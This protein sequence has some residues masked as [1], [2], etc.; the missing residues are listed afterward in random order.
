VQGASYPQQVPEERR[1]A[2]FFDLDKTIIAKSS[3]LAFGKPFFQGG[4]LN[5]RAVLRSAYAQFVFAL[6]GA[7][8]DQMDRMRSYLASMCA[9]WDVQ[10][11]RDIV[12]ETLHKV[13]DPLVHTEAVE[14]IA[15]HHETGRAVYVVSASG[16]EVVEPIAKMLGADA[17]IA[18]TMVVRDGRYTGEIEFYAYGPAKAEAIVRVADENGYDLADCYAY[19]DSVTDLPMLE[20]VGHPAAVNP[21]RALRKE[22]IQRGW[23]V[24][25]FSN[26]TPLRERIRPAAA[27]SVTLGAAG[28]AAAGAVWLLH[29]RRAKAS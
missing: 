16:S 22:A 8:E 9:G 28:L 17:A 14:L 11:V 6:A 2:A 26:A 1:A 12:D 4:L 15:S 13:I 21:D 20:A 23:Q 10:Q 24:L 19:S 7:D 5:R 25:S 3:T 29:R 27:G 18:T